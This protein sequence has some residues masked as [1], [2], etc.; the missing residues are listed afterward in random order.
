MICSRVG[1]AVRR[2]GA[3]SAPTVLVIGKSRLVL[4]ETVAG[5]R[6]LGYTAEATNDFSEIICRFDPKAIDPIVLGGQVPPDLKT[7][8]M[9]EIGAINP[10]AIFVQGLAGIP[11]LIINQVQGAFMAGR[12]GSPKHR[13]TRPSIGRY[14]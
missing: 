6:D 10:A 12:Q 14:A 3:D 9:E 7:E 2:G 4:D 8:L 5:P 13:H 1:I 11:G